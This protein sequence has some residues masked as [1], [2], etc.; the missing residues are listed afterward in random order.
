MLIEQLIFGM[1]S[2]S[3]C[4]EVIAKQPVDF[5]DAYEIASSKELTQL[6]TK[7]VNT[8]E[9]EAAEPTCK[10]GFAPVKKKKC[11]ETEGRI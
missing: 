2:R 8:N 6:S 3:I 10:L 7:V 11:Y 1:E 4:D 5:A 9:N